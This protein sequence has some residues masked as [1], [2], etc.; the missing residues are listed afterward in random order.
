M[1]PITI[2]GGGLA[3]LTLG[4]HLRQKNVPVTLHEAGTYPRHRVCGEY[5]S[6]RALSVIES[7]GLRP[8][9]HRLGAVEASDILLALG[10]SVL[11]RRTLPQPA[12]CL[13]RYEFDQFLVQEFTRLGGVIH[14]GQRVTPET[15][16]GTVLATGRQPS[17]T[18]NGWRW[19]GL[20]AHARNVTLQAG[21]EMHLSPHGYIG[22]C[23]IENQ[24]V[25]VCGLFRSRTSIPHL[26]TSWKSWLCPDPTSL[27]HQRLRQAEWNESSFSSIAAL[28]LSPQK[29]AGRSGIR[30]GDSLTM[31]PPVTGNGM[32]MAMEGAHLAAPS[33]VDWAADKIN[34]PAATQEV[35]QR[36]DSAFAPRLRHARPLQ[37]ALFHPIP[38]SIL[39]NLARVFPAIPSLL[40]RLTR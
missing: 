27:L 1:K 11:H 26:A 23:Q 13:S 22:L 36:L 10:S 15:K 32:S 8:A 33:L 34:W 35:A 18:E 39:W 14:L 29:A 28:S 38:R 30:I 20:K 7:L 12:L 21:L 4:I 25:N 37:Q 17:T 16:E 24:Q 6:G 19:F 31:I 5:L 40:F 3:G 9:L 2:L